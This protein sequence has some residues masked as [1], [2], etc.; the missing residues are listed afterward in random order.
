MALSSFR[1][2][3]A[4]VAG[5]F[6]VVAITSA[7]T[8]TATITGIVTDSSGAAVPGASVQAINQAN[9]LEYTAE[10]NS[11][12]NYVI[13]A[14]PI[15][16]YDLTATSEGFQTLL[17]PNVTLSAGTRARVDVELQVGS[18]TETVEVT[19]ELPLLES[20][21]S[22]LGQ[23]IENTTITQMPLNPHG[24][25]PPP[26][27]H[28]TGEAPQAAGIVAVSGGGRKI[29]FQSGGR[30]SAPRPRYLN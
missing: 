26:R 12:G 3:S 28:E 10:S 14:L 19:A 1:T 7:Q 30:G 9:G 22:S 16:T 15:G 5:L 23:A 2:V 11:T 21:T 24:R 20:E 13:T 17:R 27:R 6:L 4:F 29:G 18:V 25:T 8:D